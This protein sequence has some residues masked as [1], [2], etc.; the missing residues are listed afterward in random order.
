MPHN[1]KTNRKLRAGFTLIELMSAVSIGLIVVL[2]IGLLLSSG[3]RAWLNV[4]DFANSQP[5]LDA[6]NT[7]LTLGSTGR[8]SNKSDYKVYAIVNDRFYQV[9]PSSEP[10]EVVAGDAVELHYWDTELSSELMDTARTGTAYMLLYPDGDELKADFGPYPPGAIDASGNRIN[11]GDVVTAVL[12]QNV[13]SVEFS[14]TTRNFNGDGKG[15]VRMKLV[16]TEPG[17]GS[18]LTVLGATLMRNVW[19]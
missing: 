17:D 3:H 14:H 12:A 7:I 6:L 1:A 5:Q 10:E 18:D 2:V 19:P 4:F 9:V 15:C 16:L 8:K 13:S 11:G